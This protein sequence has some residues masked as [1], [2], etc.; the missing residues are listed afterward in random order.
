MRLKNYYLPFILLGAISLSAIPL[1]GQSYR[2]D[3]RGFFKNWR[4]NLNAGS[5]I[6]YG[7]LK[8][9]GILPYDV[10]YRFAY[11]LKLRKQFSPAFGIGLQVLN[12][13][14][15]STTKNPPGDQYDILE[16]D[17]SVFEYNLH[18]LLDFTGMFGGYSPDRALNAFM[19][20]GI[21]FLNWQ[22]ELFDYHTG[23]LIRSNGFTGKGPGKRTTEFVV[24]L[25]L[26]LKYNISNKWSLS[27]ETAMHA[28]N[29]DILDATEGGFAYDAYNYTSLG[30]I[31]NFNR[32][33]LQQEKEPRENIRIRQRHVRK[34]ERE[35]QKEA[36]KKQSDTYYYEDLERTGPA[37]PPEPEIKTRE[38]QDISEFKKK[39]PQKE[40]P[41][42]AEYNMK[43]VFKED[44]KS[45][46]EASTAVHPAETPSDQKL[47]PAASQKQGGKILTA[48]SD[49]PEL[50][51]S[52]EQTA[53][54]VEV[55]YGVQILASREDTD[56]VAFA[57]RFKINKKIQKETG[58]T[59][60]RYVVLQFN[61]YEEAARFR[62]HLKMRGLDDAFVV[63][64]KNGKRIPVS[65][66]K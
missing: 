29:S 55:T 51:I 1:N 60:N 9:Q 10:D 14:L 18:L 47:I 21:G 30:I 58:P 15:H 20:L 46:S 43:G 24:P 36:S 35:I 38:E 17:A 45:S 22:S 7:D 34:K 28:V 37:R 33:M 40:L 26:G 25:G 39:Y 64:Y 11:G 4:M 48:G 57:A 65:E 49:L 62:N 56:I 5:N 12:G 42:V 50:T 59:M 52:E 61:T 32:N 53:V 3:Q 27:L 19:F 16:F 54:D 6:F 63:A 31:Y 23:Q 2:A 41:V 66:V 44:K 8:D 13:K